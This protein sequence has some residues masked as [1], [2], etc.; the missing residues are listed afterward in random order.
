MVHVYQNLILLGFFICQQLLIIKEEWGLRH[1]TSIKLWIFTK[2]MEWLFLKTGLWTTNVFTKIAIFSSSTYYNLHVVIK[3]CVSSF[4]FLSNSN[5]DLLFCSC[6]KILVSRHLN[7]EYA[8]V[9]LCNILI[10]SIKSDHVF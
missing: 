7:I 5:A 4:V 10:V 9:L 2:V 3:I 8:M 1:A 6:R